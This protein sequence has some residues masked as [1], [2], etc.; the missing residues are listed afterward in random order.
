VVVDELE[1]DGG[2]HSAVDRL[3]LLHLELAHGCMVTP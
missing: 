2:V 3:A 1:H